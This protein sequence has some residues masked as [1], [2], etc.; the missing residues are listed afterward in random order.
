MPYKLN[1]NNYKSKFT[2]SFY[3]RISAI[4]TELG[5]G[6][7]SNI[8]QLR[9]LKQSKKIMFKTNFN[10]K[11]VDLNIFN[12]LISLKNLFLL[13]LSKKYLFLIRYF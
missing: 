4:N 5:E 2:D 9:I 1:L 7:Y 11:L 12:L 3:I 8:T 10:T 6:P 13:F